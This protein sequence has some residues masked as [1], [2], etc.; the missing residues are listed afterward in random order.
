MR[1]LRIVGLASF[2]LLIAYLIY[3]PTDPFA[4]QLRHALFF[5][6]RPL[7]NLPVIALVLVLY[8][9]P[10]IIAACRRHPDT[11]SIMSFNLVLGWTVAGWI[12]SLIWALRP[13][14]RLVPMPLAHAP[15][16]MTR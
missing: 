13:I 9:V 14:R 1:A 12:V 6:I 11:P 4:H 5:Q 10:A 2:M 3:S 8:K 15:D 16:S 7:A